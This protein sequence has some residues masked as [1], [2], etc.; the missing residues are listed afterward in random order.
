M[1]TTPIPATPRAVSESR[2]LHPAHVH[3]Y[4][5]ISNCRPYSRAIESEADLLGLVIMRRACYDTAYAPDFYRSS[6]STPSWALWVSTHPSDKARADTVK[7]EAAELE[8][9]PLDAATC[10]RGI[11]HKAH[12]RIEAML[13]CTPPCGLSRQE[14]LELHRSRNAVTGGPSDRPRRWTSSGGAGVS[15]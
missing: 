14:L 5:P 3:Y 1:M 9:Q 7:K 8:K 15:V 13:A 11:Q 12:P 2:V 6:H 4:Y 10:P